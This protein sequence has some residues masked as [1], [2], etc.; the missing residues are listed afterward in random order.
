MSDVLFIK[1]ETD[2]QY[3]KSLRPKIKYGRL[4]FKYICNKCGK[5][6][7]MKAHKNYKIKSYYVSY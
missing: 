2:L 1:N 3:Y 7:H 4:K 6:C 5:D